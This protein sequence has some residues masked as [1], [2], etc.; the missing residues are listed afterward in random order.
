MHRYRCSNGTLPEDEVQQVGEHLEALHGSVGITPEGVVDDARSK[1]SPLHKYFQWSDKVAAEAHRRGQARRIIGSLHVVV[2]GKEVR[3]FESVHIPVQVA[4][5]QG[6]ETTQER[7]IRVYMP[8][9]EV[10]QHPALHEDNL[11]DI[12]RRLIHFRTR[13]G[14]IKSL[15]PVIEAINQFELELEQTDSIAVAAG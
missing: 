2:Q 15:G 9:D 4:T 7:M 10:R 1:K 12:L 14:H 3:A 6:K 13:Y 8:Q 5:T 11:K